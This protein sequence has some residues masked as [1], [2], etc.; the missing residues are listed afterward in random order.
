[1]G[2]DYYLGKCWCHEDGPVAADSTG[3]ISWNQAF[4]KGWSQHLEKKSIK[5]DRMVVYVVREMS[6]ESLQTTHI[7][8]H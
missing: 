6:L 5:R 8:H 4:S 3:G 2:E 7:T 1:M